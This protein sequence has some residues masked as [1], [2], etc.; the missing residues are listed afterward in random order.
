MYPYMEAPSPAYP[1]QYDEPEATKAEVLDVVF[2]L[3]P[4]DGLGRDFD[5]LMADTSLQ[6]WA[7]RV[8]N[9]PDIE[10]DLLAFLGKRWGEAPASVRAVFEGLAEAATNQ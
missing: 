7:E 3:K 9:D 5:A 1:P 10:S 6:I 8:T 4:R 2:G